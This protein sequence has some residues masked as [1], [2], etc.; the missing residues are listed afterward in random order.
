M[1]FR[2]KK[3]KTKLLIIKYCILKLFFCLLTP[4][5]QNHTVQKQYIIHHGSQ[6]ISH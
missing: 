2:A 3:N 1:G 6:T 5:K 4:F